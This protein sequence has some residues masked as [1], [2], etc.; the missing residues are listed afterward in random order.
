MHTCFSP[1][2]YVWVVHILSEGVALDNT[3]L[4][5]LHIITIR[6]SDATFNIHDLYTG[7]QLLSWNKVAIR[8]SGCIETLVFLEAGRKCSGGPELLWM[9]HPASQVPKLRQCLHE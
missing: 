9:Y 5:G 8:R 7:K 2:V 1:T 4:T 6:S 3:A